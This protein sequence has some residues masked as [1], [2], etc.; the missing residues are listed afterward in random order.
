MLTGPMISLSILVPVY[1]EQ[2]LVAASLDRLRVLET[3]ADIG[4]IQVIVVDDCSTDRTPEILRAYEQK[5]SAVRGSRM[6]WHFARH[7][8]NRGKGAAIQT[9]LAY[10]TCE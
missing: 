6:E 7:E 1:N 5:Q 9:A 8:Q 10:A 4:R 2:H 3:S